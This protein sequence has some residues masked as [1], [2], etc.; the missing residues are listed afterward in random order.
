MADRPTASRGLEDVVMTDSSISQ[1]E[2]ERGWLVYRGFDIAE[3]ME[4]PTYESIVHLL[5][6]GD[7]PRTDP[8]EELSK[9]LAAHRDPPRSTVL[10]ADALA[11]KVPPMDALRSM[12]SLL[13]DGTLEYPPTVEQGL[14]L[15]ARAPTLLARHVRRAA[16]RSIVPPRPELGHVANYLWMLNGEESEPSKVR[17]LERYFIMLADHGMNA[18]T[19]A[20]RVVIS[21]N[22]DLASAATAALGALKGPAHG[23]APARVIEMLDAIGEPDSAGAWMAAA[24]S[25]GDRLYGYGHRA[26]KIED[27][28]SVLLKKIAE[29]IARPQRYRLAEAVERA[30]LET[31]ARAKPGRRLYTNV[32]FYAAVVLEAVGLPPELFTPTFALARTAGWA[33]HALEQ[34]SDNRLI[35]R[36]CATRG[37]RGAD[38]GTRER[39]LRRVAPAGSGP[40]GALGGALLLAGLFV[41]DLE[42]GVDRQGAGGRGTARGRLSSRRAFA[43]GGRGALRGRFVEHLGDP[44]EGLRQVR[45]VVVEP[46]RLLLGERRPKR[47]HLLADLARVALR[48]LRGVLFENPFG[49]VGQGFGTVADL[50]DPGP[51]LVLVG[52]L[53]GLVDHPVDLFL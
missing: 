21:T 12:V 30:G 50:D 18:S 9:Y 23:G 38:A 52:E 8:P 4:A 26:Y 3:L 36:M 27:P 49:F 6:Y 43:P 24:V 34:A 11:P 1:V 47:L 48:D 51:F 40:G 46:L 2:G 35:R 29:Q 32:E 13:G 22:S 25:R 19:F 44:V 16:G 37:R 31:L 7:P 20:L 5:L 10:G 28:R 17:A 39:P 33:A 41:D 53:L 15:V 42:V 45:D 14:D